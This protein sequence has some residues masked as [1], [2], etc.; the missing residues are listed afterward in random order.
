MQKPKDQLEQRMNLLKQFKER[1]FHRELI[2][3]LDFEARYWERQ[4]D[5]VVRDSNNL[6]AQIRELQQENSILIKEKNG[7]KNV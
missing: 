6:I 1:I 4:H 5:I 7:E 3:K 2:R